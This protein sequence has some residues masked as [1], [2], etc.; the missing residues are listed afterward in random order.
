VGSFELNFVRQIVF[1]MLEITL[2]ILT[3]QGN[4]SRALSEKLSIGRTN[5]ADLA[6]PDAGLSRVH[7]T[8]ERRGAE[9]WLFDENSTNGTFVNGVEVGT[10][11]AKLNN[12]DEIAL[13]SNTKIKIKIRQHAPQPEKNA[14]KPKIQNPKSNIPPVLIF[15]AALTLFIFILA[16]GAILLISLYGN[17]K[18]AAQKNQKTSNDIPVEVINGVSTNIDELNL[19]EFFSYLEV[20][21]DMNAANLEDVKGTQTEIVATDGGKTE[22]VNLNVTRAFWEQRKAKALEPRNGTTGISPP[23]LIV[24]PEL[25][26]DG[27]IKQKLKLAEMINV[28]HYQQPMDFGDLA[29]KRLNKELIELPMATDGF[30]LEVGSSAGEEEFSAFDFDNG[31]TPILSGSAKYAALQQLAANFSGQVYDLSRGSDRKQM[32][33]RLLRMFHPRALPILQELADA[34]L[35]KFNRPLRVTSLTRSMDYQIALNRVNPNSFKVKGAGSLPPHTS[36]CAFDLGRKHMTVEEQ[37]FVMQKLAE[38]E[39]RGILDALIEYNVNACFHT[40]IYPDGKTTK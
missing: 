35:K 39:N 26:G 23:G 8:I 28:M 30:Y 34:Y 19:D 13:G 33:I 18:E 4:F 15:A 36:G 3:P 11:G 31:S 20:Q 17:G 40:F 29:Q 25:R 38:M 24:P 1:Q 9:I 16:A 21:E 22:T 27:V 37:N 10:D 5:L 6:L 12:G 32:R 2:E 7:A 14:Q